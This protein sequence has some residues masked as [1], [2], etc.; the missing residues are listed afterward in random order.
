MADCYIVRRGGIG[1][2]EEKALITDGLEFA[3]TTTFSDFSNVQTFGKPSTYGITTGIAPR[4]VEIVNTC[5]TADNFII[6]YGNAVREGRICSLTQTEF[7]GFYNGM[8]YGTLA[9]SIGK[10]R[11]ICCVSHGKSMKI[12]V[13][14]IKKADGILPYDV[15]PTDEL[16]SLNSWKGNSPISS[17]GTITHEVRIYNKMLTEEEII[18]NFNFYSELYALS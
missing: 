16:F 11:H 9:Q 15:D 6:S 17:D 8:G 18:N 13:N 5:G 7:V 2:G 1:G 3:L 12:Y 4:T 10:T 14:G